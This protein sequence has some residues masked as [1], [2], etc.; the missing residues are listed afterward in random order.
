[1]ELDPRI[2]TFYREGYREDDR[3]VRSPHGR[4]ELL[5]TQELLRRLLPPAPARVLDVGGG[6]GIHAR[7]LTQDGYTVHLVDPVPSHVDLASAHGGF[8]AAIGDARALDQSDDSIDATLLLGPLYH[9]VDAA[10]RALA[11]S[12]AVRVTRPGGLLAA[13]AISRYAALLEF[14]GLG[15]LDE[16]AM[17]EIE[18]LVTTGRS[19][20][21]PSGFTTAHFHRPGELAAELVDAGLDEVVVYGIEGPAVPALDNAAPDQEAAVLDSAIRCARFV[22]TDPALIAASPH[23]LGVGR[24]RPLS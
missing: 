9:L 5:R 6:T 19:A 15:A 1:M 10:D 22:E 12:Q 13:A 2:M 11:L 8:T 16:A 3:L 17:V 4:L 7:W 14:T 24:V 23:L 18:H 20:E 21:E